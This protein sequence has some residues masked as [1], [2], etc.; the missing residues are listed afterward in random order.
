MILFSPLLPL[1]SSQEDSAK[2][3]WNGKDLNLTVPL[4]WISPLC[5]VPPHEKYIGIQGDPISWKTLRI[6]DESGN[7]PDCLNTEQ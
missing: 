6:K 2:S 5:A 1:Q 4:C 3:L 7:S